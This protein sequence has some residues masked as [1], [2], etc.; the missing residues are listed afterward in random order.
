MQSD[1]MAAVLGLVRGQGTRVLAEELNA[2][3]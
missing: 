3:Y 2:S 1:W